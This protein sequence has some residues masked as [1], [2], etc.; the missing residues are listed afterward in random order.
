MKSSEK[1]GGLL[2]HL[3]QVWCGNVGI[4][5]PIWERDRP[6]WS[7][8]SDGDIKRVLG[9]QG[10]SIEVNCIQQVIVRGDAFGIVIRPHPANR[11]GVA[12]F[13][14]PM[15]WVTAQELDEN[16]ILRRKLKRR[17]RALH[18][19]FA[20]RPCP[21]DEDFVRVEAQG[22]S[23]EQEVAEINRY[24]RPIAITRRS[25]QLNYKDRKGV[26]RNLDWWGKCA[27]PVA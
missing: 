27:V 11:N 8:K 23:E 22:S 5:P 13:D 21:G 14:T 18:P 26:E 16:D 4:A 9:S 10:S 24:K 3:V 2:F 1:D 12:L 25:V 6:T 7:G 19:E 15:F 20:D 17:F